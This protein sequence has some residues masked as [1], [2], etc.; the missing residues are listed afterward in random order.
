MSWSCGRADG[1]SRTDGL[2]LHWNG[3]GYEINHVTSWEGMSTMDKNLLLSR[4]S[5]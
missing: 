2:A 5:Y 4:L 3:V 1:L